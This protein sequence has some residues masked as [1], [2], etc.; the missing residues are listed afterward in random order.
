MRNDRFSALP[1]TAVL[2]VCLLLASCAK[3]QDAKPKQNSVSA[4]SP[5]AESIRFQYAV[6]M[7][8]VHTH[9]PAVV[10][11]EELKKYTDLKLVNEIPKEPQ[12]RLVCAHN[13]ANVQKEYAPPS[14]KFLQYFGHGISSR[15][16][17]ALQK[18]R[19]AFVLDFAH[20]KNNVWEGLHAANG[21]VE[22]IARKTGGL[23]WDEETREIFTPDAWHS[24][25]LAS[26]TDGV[27]DV[28]N[29]TTIH[30]YPHNEYVRAITLGMAKMGLPDVVAG[31][32]VWSSSDQAGDLIN[33][34]CQSMAE[35]ARIETPGKFKLDLRAIKDARVREHH[36]ES[37]G[38][39]GT[40]TACVS[41]E[42]ALWQEGD[43]KNRLI[44]ITS[45]RY[46][47]PDAYARQE[48]MLSTFFGASDSITH[49]EHSPELLEASRRARE[50]L[51][52]LHKM[53]SAGLEPDEFIEVKA[54]FETPDGGDEWMWVEITSWH[55]DRIK[56]LLENDPFEVPDLH[57]G[58]I[59]E[60]REED[61]FDY[62]HQYPDKHQE[63]NTTSEILR[64][65]EEEKKKNGNLVPTQVKSTSQSAVP[66]C[67]S[68]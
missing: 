28:S 66:L 38:S 11:R 57:S 12:A 61:V 18:S 29:Q 63:G 1:V 2:S 21:L 3:K 62:I 67:D 19:E 50:K 32:F 44:E 22:D 46:A 8:P 39:S 13:Q 56:G 48:N 55:G 24:R 53:F 54:P 31:D 47:G 23:V 65:I 51:P 52:E 68:D 5:M 49:V 16:A 40:G 43:P 42:P 27:P 10:L 33:I 6:Y 37:L 59:V 7:L 30:I 45:D 25:R 58:Q 4:P 9:D 41:L 64:K 26:W 15:Q 60:V 20:P 34:F 17:Q 36:M 14:M 35:G